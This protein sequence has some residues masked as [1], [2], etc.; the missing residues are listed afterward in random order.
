[1]SRS[2]R[3]PHVVVI[4][5]VL[6]DIDVETTAGRLVPDS[7]APVLDEIGRRVRAGGAGLA[8]RFVA[9]DGCR[10]TLVTAVPDDEAGAT[11]L[12]S[13]G[14]VR[15][16]LLPCDGATAVKMR[17]R[18]GSQTVARLDQGGSG[19]Q[20]TDLPDAVA[21]VLAD[22]DAVLVSDYGRGV[23]AHPPLLELLAETARRRPIVWDP[24]PRGSTPVRGARVVTPNAGE[25]AGACES[26]VAGSVADACRQARAL[27][28][29][30]QVAGVA[31]TIGPRGAVLAAGGDSAA[32]FPPPRPV[33][34]DPC[35]AGDR[36]AARVASAL[37]A[38]ALSSEAVAD[39]VAAATEFLAAGGVASLD[40]PAAAGGETA[41]GDAAEVIAAV[42]ARGGTVVATGGCFDLLH[43]GHVGTLEAA[44]SL[45][46]CLI[47]CVNSDESVRRRKGPDR[48]VQTAA[49]RVR[50]LEALS[51]VDAVVVFDEDTP[52]RL[53]A[54]L[55]PD[56]WVK[57]GDY[58][59]TEL[60]E[61][62]L[63]RS[64]HGEVV[65]VPYLPGRSTT[66]LLARAKQ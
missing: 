17:L 13:L 22:A 51:A 53:L 3:I 46:D 19:L 55:R 56:I 33:G 10:V 16:V 66:R 11:I 57:G 28:E 49:D 18:R 15:R 40:E 9:D 64:W 21:G 59:G 1:M 5:D 7:A 4:G 39:A 63:V 43:A 27:V 62:S 44:R 29:Q 38:G 47:V 30:W 52:E 35:G 45:G 2:S 37:A 61:T 23:T 36:F 31:V 42:R 24:H 50:V 26:P 20:V 6:L 25:A 48:P 34:G 65:T 14:D 60:P 12:A 54:E 41:A 8:A 58:A 32:V